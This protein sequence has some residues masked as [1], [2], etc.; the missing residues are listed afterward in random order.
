MSKREKKKKGRERERKRKG[1]RGEKR[2]RE[3]ERE[4]GREINDDKH[5]QESTRHLLGVTVDGTPLFYSSYDGGKV[6]VSED[7]GRGALSH[8]RTTP[9]GHANVSAL[10]RGGIVH[11]IASL[12]G[13]GVG[14]YIYI[15]IYRERERE[16]ER[17]EHRRVAKS[18]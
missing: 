18:D 2:E 10:Q 14:I 15:Y 8:S 6:V 5:N 3:K 13:I 9:H 7:H 1:E 17:N 4:K 12:K 16:R 11:T